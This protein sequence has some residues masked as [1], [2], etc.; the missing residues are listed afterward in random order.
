MK[1]RAAL[2]ELWDDCDEGPDERGQ[3][4]QRA[5]A[6]ITGFIGAHLPRG[7]ADAYTEDEIRL[8]DARGSSQQPFAP[9][10]ATP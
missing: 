2:F 10:P 6:M 1:R 7:S 4:G 8:L 5:R 3:A 9:Y